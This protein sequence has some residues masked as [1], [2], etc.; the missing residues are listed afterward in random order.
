MAPTRLAGFVVAALA[1]IAGMGA[2]CA[3]AAT[4]AS[5]PGVELAQTAAPG[6]TGA[7]TPGQG[8]AGANPSSIPSDQPPTE[9]ERGR[10]LR[11]K[12]CLRVLSRT[13]RR[14]LTLLYGLDGGSTNPADAVAQRTG[15]AIARVQS[16]EIRALRRLRRAVAA[17]PRCG[18]PAPSVASPPPAKTARP[19]RAAAPTKTLSRRNVGLGLLALGLTGLAG[20]LLYTMREIRRSL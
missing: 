4:A 5:G 15:L 2:L 13:D 16:T 3:G 12:R 20:A 9:L 17:G 1:A 11:L 18:D 19:V 14:V 10:V 7:T 6:G 8:A